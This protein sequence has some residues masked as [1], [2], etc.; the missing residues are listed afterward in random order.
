M[1]RFYCPMKGGREGCLR[2]CISLAHFIR[3]LGIATP[4]EEP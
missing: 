3:V 1:L 4:E 2:L